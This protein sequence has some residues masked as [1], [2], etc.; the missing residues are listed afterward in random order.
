[1]SWTPK[2]YENRYFGH[3]TLEYALQESLNSATARL[4]ETV[5]LDRLPAMGAKLGFS[6]L[7]A[8][9]SIVLGGIDVTPMQ[10]A[11]AYA[12]FANE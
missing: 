4:A 5:G 10:I 11:D 2:N 8:Y 9:P 7:P 6:G 3:V 1:M 12:V